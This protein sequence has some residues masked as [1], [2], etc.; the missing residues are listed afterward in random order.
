[1]QPRPKRRRWFLRKRLLV[2]LGLLALFAVLAPRAGGSPPATAGSQL[3]EPVRDGNL[4]F[5]VSRVR[6]GVDQ[7]GTGVLKRSPKGQFCLVDVKVTNVK[8]DAR[9]LYEPFQKLVD[10]AGDKHGADIAARFVYRDQNLWDKVQ[11]GKRVSG[12]MVFDIPADARPQRLELHD[13][14]ISGGVAVTLR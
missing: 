3:N 2:P 8:D 6:C 7:I 5:V 4:E 1:M 14:P 13:G 10:T 11:P 9:T 12:T